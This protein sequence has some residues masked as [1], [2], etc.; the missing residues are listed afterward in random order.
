MIALLVVLAVIV[1]A[2]AVACLW[3]AGT[4]CPACDQPAMDC[5]CPV[6]AGE[7]AELALLA[8]EADPDFVATQAAGYGETADEWATRTGT[9]PTRH[10]R[11]ANLPLPT[12]HKEAS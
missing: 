10:Q 4:P 7:R 3:A 11:P 2:V 6:H 12:P 5:R 9:Q 1:V 8:G